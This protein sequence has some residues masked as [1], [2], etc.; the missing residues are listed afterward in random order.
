[1][2]ATLPPQGRPRS[3]TCGTPDPVITCL[4]EVV[5]P[6]PGSRPE[7]GVHRRGARG[8]G[9]C[10]HV[11]PGCTRRLC[12]GAAARGVRAIVGSPA[13]QRK[14]GCDRREEAREGAS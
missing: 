1:M 6:A 5:D 2:T 11:S 12:G 4:H 7:G 14:E 10:P 13:R 8:G 3:L 9:G